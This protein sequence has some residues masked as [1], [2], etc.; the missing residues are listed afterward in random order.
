MAQQS[1]PT[2]CRRFEAP[3][4]EQNTV[5][6]SHGIGPEPTGHLVGRLIG[7]DFDG[8]DAHVQHACHERSHRLFE[9][10]RQALGYSARQWRGRGHGLCRCA[11]F[12]RTP[13]A[14]CGFGKDVGEPTDGLGGPLIDPIVSRQR[15]RPV[16][17]HRPLTGK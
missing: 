1:Q 8:W 3:G 11:R 15:R 12:I 16:S 6:I 7:V 4:T 10:Q 13:D 5:L 17:R 14:L 9:A 2:R